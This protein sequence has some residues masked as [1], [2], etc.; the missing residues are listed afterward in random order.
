MTVSGGYPGAF[1]KGFAFSEVDTKGNVFHAG[2]TLKE[3][4]IMTSGGR[5]AACTAMGKTLAEALAVSMNDAEKI[6]FNGKYYRSDI[7]KDLL[8]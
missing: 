2:T 8:S 5:V 4:R 1:E 7:G 3:G 6:S